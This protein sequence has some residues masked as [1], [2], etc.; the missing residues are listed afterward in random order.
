M[1]TYTKLSYTQTATPKEGGGVTFDIV[2]KFTPAPGDL[3]D[4]VTGV[5]VRRVVSDNDEKLDV[6]VRVAQVGDLGTAASTR[7]I[8]ISGV[9]FQPAAG[10]A[11]APSAVTDAKLYLSDTVTLSFEDLQVAVQAKQVLEQRVDN[12]LT[13]WK[14]YRDQF[15]GVSETSFPLVSAPIVSAARTAYLAAVTA[16]TA[17]VDK[18][19]AISNASKAAEDDY[20]RASADLA[21]TQ[22]LKGSVCPAV[23]LL[24]SFIGAYD[25][26]V[27]PQGV[28]NTLLGRT[29]DIKAAADNLLEKVPSSETAV[30]DAY[31]TKIT[32]Y[33]DAL[34]NHRNAAE[35]L[36]AARNNTFLTAYTNVQTACSTLSGREAY[37]QT[38]KTQARTA[39]DTAR[40]QESQARTDVNTASADVATK[41][42]ALLA[43]CPDFDPNN[44]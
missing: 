4:G 20:T 23:S 17:A 41:L 19:M 26:Y 40:A 33:D 8:A 42:S 24:D 3:P 21:A 34:L 7:T 18:L 22:V 10:N 36:T 5:F 28:R 29:S 16:Q 35:N 12:L 11:F 31:T 44:P 43:V 9:R 6:F 38:K 25:S 13:Q 39:A 1:S 30:R 14:T 15:V 2:A 37:L 27:S 32:S